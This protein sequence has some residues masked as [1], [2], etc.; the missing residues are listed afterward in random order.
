M[1]TE[2]LV[3]LLTSNKHVKIVG[4]AYALEDALPYMKEDQLDMLVI[5]GQSSF[6]QEITARLF[7]SYSNLSVL[8]VHPDKTYMDLLRVSRVSARYADLAST[9][10]QIS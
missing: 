4:C 9:I 10:E 2:G 5:A 3:S 7:G 6:I 1:L 8:L